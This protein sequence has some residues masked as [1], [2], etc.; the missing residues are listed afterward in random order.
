MI[1]F[2]RILSLV[3]CAVLIAACAV[4]GASAAADNRISGAC[5]S[6]AGEKSD[7]VTS[8]EG[9]ARVIGEPSTDATSQTIP[10][11]TAKS[12][13][14]VALNS[15]NGSVAT[16]EGGATVWIFAGIIGLLAAAGI[17]YFIIQ[18]NKK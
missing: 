4:F 14:S 8:N 2:K 18:K 16:N 3:L 5:V 13:D 6:V 9:A 11:S 7:P 15:A 1:G 10:A 12:A 17:I